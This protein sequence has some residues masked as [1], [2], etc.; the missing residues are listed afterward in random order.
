MSDWHGTKQRDDLKPCPFCGGKAVQQV[1][2]ATSD[3]GMNWRI[4]CGNP[5]CAVE[6]NTPPNASLQNAEEAWQE[7]DGLTEPKGFLSEGSR[8]E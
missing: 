5:F 8:S 1:R 6:P 4:G 2:L 7:R 3:T